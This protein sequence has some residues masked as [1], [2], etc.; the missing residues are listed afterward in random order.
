MQVQKVRSEPD[1]A[2]RCAVLHS[3]GGEVLSEI[4]GD[5]LSLTCTT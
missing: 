3:K 2:V 4:Q 1:S 5:T